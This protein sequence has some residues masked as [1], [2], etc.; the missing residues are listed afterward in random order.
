LLR[1]IGDIG[2]MGTLDFTETPVTNFTSFEKEGAGTWTLQGD[3]S[4]LSGNWSVNTGMLFVDGDLS[5]VDFILAGGTLLGGT[6]TLGSLLANANSIVSPGF[7]IGTLNVDGDVSFGIASTF[8]VEIAPDIGGDSYGISDRLEATGEA[9]IQGGSV[10]VIKT[11]GS[12]AAG[13][14]W[15]ILRADAGGPGGEFDL[16]IQDEPLLDLILEYEGGDTDPYLVYLTLL[17]DAAIG[18]LDAAQTFNQISTAVAV[19]DV[20]SDVLDAF[21]GLNEDEARAALDNLSGEIHATAFGAVFDS[22]WF[23]Q[24]MLS[25]LKEAHGDPPSLPSGTPP[26]TALAYA[27]EEGGAASG[28][29]G[30]R[31]W[32]VRPDGYLASGHRNDDGNAAAAKIGTGGL[33]IGGDRTTSDVT[34]GFAGGFQHD[35]ISVPDRQST[36]AIDTWNLGTYAG[37]T[38]DD[39]W[40]ARGG[41]ALAHHGFD[42]TRE[43]VV[44]GLES[45]A[46]ASYAGWSGQV[47]GEVGRRFAMD[48]FTAEPYAGLRLAH[49]SRDAFSETGAGPASLSAEAES[50]SA[51]IAILGIDVATTVPLAD[52]RLLKPHAG[53]AWEHAFADM[54]PSA[55]LMFPGGAATFHILGPTAGRDTFRL[56]A[57]ADVTLSATATAFLAWQGRLAAGAHQHAVRGGATVRF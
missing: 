45:T 13:T 4:G 10:G 43:I 22:P 56:D 15:L 12:Y 51:L 36:A 1:L 19:D 20:G 28:V 14:Q 38:G 16:L 8:R 27:P 42:T 32:A 2:T 30:W 35:S 21:L 29:P 55:D 17:S 41:A 33:L 11:I 24:G 53:V 46:S 6:G 25:R 48:G 23:R 57:G 9:D 52:G 26:G 40:R 18:V 54:T 50:K 3:G 34:L 49:A 47:F 37:W 7:S 5:G 39:G 44:P 31:W